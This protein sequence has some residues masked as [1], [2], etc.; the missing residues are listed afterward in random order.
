MA[1]DT[2]NP[3]LRQIVEQYLNRPLEPQ[4]ALLLLNFQQGLQPQ[5]APPIDAR[6]QAQQA[7][8]Q[9]RARAVS[10]VRDTLEAIQA[11]TNQALQVQEKQEQAI[12]KLFEDSRPLAELRPSSQQAGNQLA[13]TQIAEHLANLARQEVKNCF[14]ET[15][16]PLTEQLQ[17][18]VQRRNEVGTQVASA[19]AP[20]AAAEEVYDS[21]APSSK[22]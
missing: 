13:L 1:N 21:A 17:A 14:Q 15:F 4:E 12:L 19:T 5:S 9:G 11:S 2:L 18:L 8:S 7:I 10:S 22:Q 6:Q 20:P 3:E 16:G